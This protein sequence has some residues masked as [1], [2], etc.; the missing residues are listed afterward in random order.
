MG[1]IADKV[2]SQLVI[3]EMLK[4]FGE[5]RVA[6]PEHQPKVFEYQMKLAKHIVELN[7]NSVPIKQEISDLTQKTE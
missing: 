6:H 1:L 7:N 2:M 3:D 4:I 5:E